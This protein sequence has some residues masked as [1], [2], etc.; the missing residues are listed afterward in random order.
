MK[1]A[2]TKGS[3]IVSQAAFCCFCRIPDET[4]LDH[5]QQTRFKKPDFA[6]SAKAPI[7]LPKKGLPQPRQPL[8]PA[9]S[10]TGQ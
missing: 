1:P 6:A 8:S 7:K 10:R 3:N 9:H 2:K 4:R 5:R